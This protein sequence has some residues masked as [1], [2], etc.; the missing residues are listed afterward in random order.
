MGERKKDPNWNPR[1]RNQ[2][3]PHAPGILARYPVSPM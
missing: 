2:G 1:M 3:N